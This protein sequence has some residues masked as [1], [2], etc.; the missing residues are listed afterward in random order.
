MSRIT[1][2]QCENICRKAQ[3][4]P[5]HSSMSTTIY[6]MWRMSLVMSKCH[7]QRTCVCGLLFQF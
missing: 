1:N 6:R 4:R 3:P 5:W 7:G 2:A